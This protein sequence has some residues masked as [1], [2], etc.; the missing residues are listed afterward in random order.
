MGKRGALGV[1]QVTCAVLALVA[2]ATIAVSSGN[3]GAAQAHGPAPGTAGADPVAEAVEGAVPVLGPAEGP[4]EPAGEP[5]EAGQG[6][7]SGADGGVPAA[8]PAAAPEEAPDAPEGQGAGA[9]SPAYRDEYGTDT[10]A[11]DGSLTQWA[12]GYYIAHDWSENGKAIA[13]GRNVVIDGREYA[14]AGSQT[15]PPGTPYED[16][17]GWV[18]AD[19]G[20]GMQTCTEGGYIVNRYVPVA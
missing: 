1:G 7:A 5:A 9:W 4:A 18:H 8:G 12:D 2:A 15:V 16:V 19:G 14:L 17:E 10:A 13:S 6:G 3:V 11:D 20:I